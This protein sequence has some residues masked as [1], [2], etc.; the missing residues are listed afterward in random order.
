LALFSLVM[1]GSSALAQQAP[2]SCTASVPAKTCKAVT[3]EFSVL[4]QLSKVFASQ[5]E[6]VVAD[7]E[8]FK[9]EKDR[10]E[11]LHENAMKAA[12]KEDNRDLWANLLTHPPIAETSLGGSVLFVL[13]DDGN[14]NIKKIVISSDLFRG[15]NLKEKPTV[16]QGN[17]LRFQP[18]DFDERLVETWSSYVFGYWEGRFYGSVKGL[19]PDY[20]KRR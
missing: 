3:D 7:S 6:I 2:I 1:A 12:D 19:P 9:R 15:V 10:L 13:E 17:V 11:A 20:G 5:V 14:R 18:G 8:A 16:D 4:Q